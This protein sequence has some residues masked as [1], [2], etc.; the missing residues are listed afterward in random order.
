M[1]EKN[2]IG[3]LTKEMGIIDKDGIYFYTPSLFAQENLCYLLWGAKYTCISPYEVQRKQNCF[4]SLL[5]FYIEEG[6]IIFNYRGKEFIANKHDIIL[7]NCNYPHK[8]KAIDKVKFYW[9][10]FNGNVA[11]AYEKKFYQEYGAI[12]NNQ[13][14]KLFEYIL[15]IFKQSTV[16]DDE[17]SLSIQR[18]FLQI[19]NS[20]NE[21]LYISSPILKAKLTIEENFTKDITVDELATIANLSKFHFS[22]LF[23]QEVKLSPYAYLL[24]IR[25]EHAK[26]LLS[27]TEYSIEQISEV[28]VFYS[29]SNFIRIFRKYTGMTPLQFRK[30][31]FNNV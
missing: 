27:E 31:F 19:A 8:Y 4:D 10:H 3:I 24:Q 6:S 2:S 16:S 25:L 9:F 11:K 5:F 29:A 12:F 7:L 15:Y 22:R 20:F 13:S 28:C 17:I 21:A 26:K 23:R 30:L 14:G 1:N 18:I